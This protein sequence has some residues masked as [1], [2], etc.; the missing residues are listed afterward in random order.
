[1]TTFDN[2]TS[3]VWIRRM[4]D[5][6]PLCRGAQQRFRGASCGSSNH[7][8]ERSLSVVAAPEGRSGIALRAGSQILRAGPLKTSVEA[9]Q[10]F[11]KPLSRCFCCGAKGQALVRQRDYNIAFGLRAERCGHCIVSRF[12]LEIRAGA[13]LRVGLRSAG[14]GPVPAACGLEASLFSRPP[15][16]V[17]GSISIPICCG[18]NLALSRELCV[19][20]RRDVCVEVVSPSC[21]NTT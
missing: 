11:L 18:A 21:S 14:G 13:A 12:G 15:A 3:A 1:M 8:A 7:R 6:G 9:P 17:P 2:G 20:A 16:A 5:F 4:S 10:R 19:A